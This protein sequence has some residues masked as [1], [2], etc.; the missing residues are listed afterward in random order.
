MLKALVWKEFRELLPMVALALVAEFAL[1]CSAM[2]MRLGLATMERGEIPFIGTDLRSFVTHVPAIFAIVMALWQTWWESSRGTFLFLL[3]RPL[4]RSEIVAAKLL[5]GTALCLIVSFLPSFGYALWA[6]AP[7]THASPFDWSMTASTWRE[8]L[9]IPG[10]YFGGFLSGL[11]P[12]RWFVSRFFP[13]AASVAM[14]LFQESAP[15]G[16][17]PLLV[18]LGLAIDAYFVWVIFNVAATRDFS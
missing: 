7:G 9:A 17:A 18:G 4:P 3:H 14:L 16:F 13:L 1:V 15:E 10:L 11:R 8:C 6:A 12:A 5:L 2:G